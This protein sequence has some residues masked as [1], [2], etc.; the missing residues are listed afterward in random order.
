MKKNLAMAVFAL[1]MLLAMTGASMAATYAFSDLENNI[2]YSLTLTSTG[3]NTYDAVFNISGVPTPPT[4][5]Y[6]SAFT[7]KFGSNDSFDITSLTAPAGF[8]QPWLVADYDT[9]SGVQVLTGGTYKNLLESNKVGFYN[10][11]VSSGQP[12][13]SV[14]EVAINSSTDVEFLFDFSQSAVGGLDAIADLIAFKALYLTNDGTTVNF[15]GWLSEE[16]AVVPVPEPG[17]MMLLGSGLVGLAAW[18]RKKFR[19]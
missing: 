6:A 9:N 3:A 5:F 10:F 18:G 15:Q 4:N 16:L 2:N 8:T 7:F 17:T 12:I 1:F 11:Y 19:K 13:T 14:N